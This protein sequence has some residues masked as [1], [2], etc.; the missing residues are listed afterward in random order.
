MLRIVQ[1]STAEYVRDVLPHSASIWAG[2]RSFADYAAEFGA[3]SASGFGR[4]RFRTL[5]L[6]LDGDVVTSCKRYQ[7][8]LRCGDRTFRA[9]GIGAVF[10]PESERGRGYA[11]AFLG[12]L[13]DAERGNGTDLVYLFSDI[14]PAFYERLGF[15]TLPSRALA[16][17]AD[18]LPH[19]RIPGRTLGDD[20]WPAIE[21]C[22][23]AL[24]ATRDFALTRPPL[25]WDWLRLRA[26]VREGSGVAVR[27][28]VMRGRRLV[29][30]VLGRRFPAVDAFALDEF[31]YV[32]DDAGALVP[33]LIRNAAGD[34][35]KVT[36]WLPPAPA[37]ARIPRGAVRAR[38]TGITMILPLS[39]AAAA[40]WRRAA[41]AVTSAPADPCWNADHV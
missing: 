35:R 15:V 27:L 24:D 37:R 31:A 19:A 8:E 29:A 1:L 39:K 6:S 36:G 5:G 22:F 30:Y 16:L 2:D 40:A 13:L 4:R 20:D 23:A 9:A 18:T 38:R 26:R 41:P 10:T 17:R 21:R 7:R 11:T 34:L 28:G 25:F 3:A 33:A 12:A 32:D 14:H